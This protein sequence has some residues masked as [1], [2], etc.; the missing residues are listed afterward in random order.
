MKDKNPLAVH[1]IRAA[2]TPMPG[3]R[4]AA[5][6]SKLQLEKRTKNDAILEK[7]AELEKALFQL[8]HAIQQL[9][10][11]Q[12]VSDLERHV[13]LDLLGQQV[14]REAVE[15]LMEKRAEHFGLQVSFQNEKVNENEQDDSNEPDQGNTPLSSPE[16][17]E[18]PEN[19]S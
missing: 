8:N 5:Q 3:R 17:Y 1:Q 7:L 16:G 12:R 13:A 18:S 2:G 19:Y 10:Q 6:P 9:H 15:S 14:G 11:A 4:Q